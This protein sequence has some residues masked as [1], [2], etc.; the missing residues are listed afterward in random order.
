MQQSTFWTRRRYFVIAGV[1]SFFV[2]IATGSC[3]LYVIQK[4][5]RTEIP[6]V[7]L[8]GREK[9]I[10]IERNKSTQIQDRIPIRI[11]KFVPDLFNASNLVRAVLLDEERRG[12]IID[13]LAR[14]SWMAFEAY[15]IAQK[16]FAYPKLMISLARAENFNPDLLFRPG[17]LKDQFL[18]ENLCDDLITILKKC[19][20]TKNMPRLALK[21]DRALRYAARTSNMVSE[22]LMGLAGPPSETQKSKFLLETL[23]E[24]SEH[25]ECCL[26][27][28]DDG[29]IRVLIRLSKELSLNI[30][31]YRCIVRILANVSAVAYDDAL[32]EEITRSGL[33]KMLAEWSNSSDLD[34]CL[35]ASKTLSNLDKESDP[36][37]Y[38]SGVYLLHPLKL[39]KT[40]PVFDIV[41]VHGLRGGVLKTWRQN[42]AAR[43]STNRQQ[44]PMNVD[45][46]YL[47]TQCWPKD[48]LPVD[49]P[50]S[51]IIA[52]DYETSFV[53]PTFPATGNGG[54]SGVL[55][56]RSADLLERLHLAGIG[57]R[58]VFWI[59]HSMGGLLVKQMLLLSLEKPETSDLLKKT[60][61]CVFYSTP[62]LGSPFADQM[63]RLFKVSP[64]VQDLRINNPYLLK[65]Q[66]KF[67]HLV[68]EHALN[69]LSFGETLP[70]YR[71]IST[72]FVPVDSSN[73][74]IG[75]FVEL[76][77]ATH[78]VSCKPS[79]P[80]S[81]MYCELINFLR[82]LLISYEDNGKAKPDTS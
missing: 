38:T 17:K 7:T 55:E 69:L 31:D 2:G 39:P 11:D 79:H 35:R 37:F 22:Y 75:K 74:R 4:W 61:G 78:F 62:H 73:M 76:G 43:R 18:R 28:R 27:M 56:L 45:E 6:S 72:R 36:Y 80:R 41:F 8:D 46:P 5:R 33:L 26:K 49:F 47:H 65:L 51:R 30:D 44:L 13:D 77:D 34:L 67:S 1:G 9:Y 81:A 50:S 23:S 40:E 66:E 15:Q 25:P 68:Q 57:K 60:L 64:E 12:R 48:W 59:S 3:T 58:P 70:D 63:A 71:I 32:L 82:E 19:P 20:A 29:I 53:L 52:V 42:D 14:R 54:N 21:K 16:A 24:M 10:Y